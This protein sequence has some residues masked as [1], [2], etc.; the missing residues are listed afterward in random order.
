MSDPEADELTQGVD[1]LCDKLAEL[2]IDQLDLKNPMLVATVLH[3]TLFAMMLKEL[4]E[5]RLKLQR[6][7]VTEQREKLLGNMKSGPFAHL[8]EKRRK[9]AE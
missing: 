8:R 1:K 6:D 7:S 9:H 3:S 5:I 2:N 4:D